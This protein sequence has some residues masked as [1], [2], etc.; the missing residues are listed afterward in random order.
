MPGKRKRH[1]PAKDHDAP[2]KRIK[3]DGAG[4]TVASIT[5]PTLS[6]YYPQ[7]LTLRDYALSKLP[8]SS[9]SRRRRIAAVGYYGKNGHSNQNTQTSYD[10]NAALAKLLDGT[11]ICRRPSVPGVALE[12]RQKDFQAFSQRHDGVDESS[13]L[14]GSTPQSEV[15]LP[16]AISNLRQYSC[17]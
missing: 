14:E 9:K 1:R 4:A 17:C 3:K 10:P 2:S 15:S 6:L 16:N 7:I 11:L 12:I 8:V 13:L 5:H